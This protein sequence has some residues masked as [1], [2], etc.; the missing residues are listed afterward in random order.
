VAWLVKIETDSILIKEKR[1]NTY[2][3]CRTGCLENVF[4]VEMLEV[5]VEKVS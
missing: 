4:R 5:Q 1:I 3:K 2:L